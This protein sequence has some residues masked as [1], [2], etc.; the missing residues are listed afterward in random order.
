[1]KSKLLPHFYKIIGLCVFLL[2]FVT[3]IIMGLLHQQS[4]EQ[5]ESR[6]QIANT[7]MLVGLLLFILSKEKTEDEFVD[8]CRLIAFRAAFIAGIIY[9]LQDAFGAFKGNLVNSSFGLLIMEI[10]VYVIIFYISKAGWFN[11]K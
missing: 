1:M 7:I 9:F 3:P 11:G 4:W 5:T 8:Y 6:R 10:G 2:A